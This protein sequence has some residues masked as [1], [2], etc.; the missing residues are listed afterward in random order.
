MNDIR[1]GKRTRRTATKISKEDREILKKEG[2]SCNKAI[3][4]Y[5]DNILL[6]DENIRL[7]NKRD[8]LCNLLL[9]EVDI[10]LLKETNI[11]Y[12]KA[13]EE[14]IDKILLKGKVIE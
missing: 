9:T 10:E 3:E 1:L 11:S 5:I 12:N 2:I 4:R 14:Y 13:I 8:K 7:R 6:H